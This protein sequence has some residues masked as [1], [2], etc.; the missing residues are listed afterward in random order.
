MEGLGGQ[1][2][3]YKIIKKEFQIIKKGVRNFPNPAKTS[4]SAITRQIP[5]K[6]HI[7]DGKFDVRACR[8]L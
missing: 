6:S 1:G 4:K 5:S 8:R 2:Y 7:F 3:A